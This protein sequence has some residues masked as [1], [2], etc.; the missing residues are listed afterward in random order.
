MK[1]IMFVLGLGLG[2]WLAGRF[3]GTRGM[4]AM[5]AQS[6]AVSAATAAV[7]AAG[8]DGPREAETKG[9][10]A[11]RT[12]RSVPTAFFLRGMVF[13]LP[14]T[15]GLSPEELA[16]PQFA[17][18]YQRAL[19]ARARDRVAPFVLAL[20][21]NTAQA[22]VLLE[23][24]AEQSAEWWRRTYVTHSI[25]QKVRDQYAMELSRIAEARLSSVLTPGQM[26]KLAGLKYTGEGISGLVDVFAMRGAPLPRDR[27]GELTKPEVAETARGSV[28]YQSVN[29]FDPPPPWMSEAQR[30]YLATS[31]RMRAA[32]ELTEAIRGAWVKDP[33]LRDIWPQ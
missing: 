16:D 19:L 11:P 18:I 2:F 15:S 33:E 22:G 21:L 13:G 12:A 3:T 1:A 17:E 29:T 6:K 28:A 7:T 26:E 9:T 10:T 8:P 5:E 32:Y 30:Q 14:D 24:A 20:E 4:A 27:A 31:Q 25:P 23:V